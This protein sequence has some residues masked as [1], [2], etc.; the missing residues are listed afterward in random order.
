MEK[1][2]GRDLGRFFEGW[3]FDA[4]LPTV[5]VRHEIEGNVATVRLEQRENP[6]DFPVTARITYHSGQSENVVLIASGPLAEH[7]VPLKDKVRRISFNED[8]GTLAEIR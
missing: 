6:M 3:V 1:A 7:K 4:A 8:H 5:H 2:T